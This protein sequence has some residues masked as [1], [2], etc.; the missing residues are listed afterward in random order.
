MTKTIET[1]FVTFFMA[2]STALALLIA[3]PAVAKPVSEAQLRDRLDYI[4][5]ASSV[6]VV[7]KRMEKECRAEWRAKL[8]LA[9]QRK[10]AAERAKLASAK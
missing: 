3:S 4:C 10:A 2:V 8:Q 7:G 6:D 5:E 1:A 9:E